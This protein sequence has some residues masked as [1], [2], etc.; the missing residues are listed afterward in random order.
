M[1]MIKRVTKRDDGYNWFRGT[2]RGVPLYGKQDGAK[3]YESRIMAQ[4]EIYDITSVG[5]ELQIIDVEAI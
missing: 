1:F 3:R 5:E 2:L 4:N